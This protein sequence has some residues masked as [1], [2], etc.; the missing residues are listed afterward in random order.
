MPVTI[1]LTRQPL[2]ATQQG[3][4]RTLF[5]SPAFSLFK[6][7]VASRCVDKQ[8][9]AMN[10]ALY[11]DN[12]AAASDAAANIAEASGLSALLDIID[13]LAANE[14]DWWTVKLEPRR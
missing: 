2:D 11:P 12:E 5:D 3:S 14:Q 13:D 10:A 6:E 9:F 1:I 7:M 4:L 8:V